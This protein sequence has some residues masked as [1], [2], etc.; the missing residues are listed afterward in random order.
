M[1][2]YYLDD[3]LEEINAALKESGEMTVSDL[4]K[5]FTFPFQF[6]SEFI[7][8]NLK[9]IGGD[10]SNTNNDNNNNN[11]NNNNDNNNGVVI[12][13]GNSNRKGNVIDGYLD[14]GVLY[15]QMFVR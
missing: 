1:A 9:G 2:Q 6:L 5:R 14:G 8:R 11:N 4:C 3:V 12:S 10:D 7:E 13:I 15:T